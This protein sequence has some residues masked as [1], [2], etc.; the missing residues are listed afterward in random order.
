MLFQFRFL[1][2][3][4]VFLGIGFGFWVY[5]NTITV[6]ETISGQILE[7]TDKNSSKTIYFTFE[8]LRPKKRTQVDKITLFQCKL[9]NLEMSDEIL[10]KDDIDMLMISFDPPL[11]PEYVDNRD[12]IFR[13][14]KISLAPGESYTGPFYYFNWSS[15][16]PVGYVQ[17]G[18][19]SIIIDKQQSRPY[20]VTILPNRK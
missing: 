8:I 11:Y 19:M 15:E 16:V 13:W 4:T 3:V 18:Y 12:F 5:L 1:I 6:A 2:L 9:T 7:Y 20:Q 10:D 17:K 14:R